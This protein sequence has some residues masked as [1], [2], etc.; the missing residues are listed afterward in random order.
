MKLVVQKKISRMDQLILKKFEFSWCSIFTDL[1]QTVK[2]TFERN[3]TSCF[4]YEEPFSEKIENR[5]TLVKKRIFFPLA[6]TSLLV[7]LLKKK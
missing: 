4:N 3:P 5:M 2:N 7:T 6:K 1:T